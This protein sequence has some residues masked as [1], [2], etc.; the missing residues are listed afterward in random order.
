TGN[1]TLTIASG[2]LLHMASAGSVAPAINFGSAEGMLLENSLLTINGKVSG[3]GGLTKTG[4]G[5]ATL[6]S[7]ASDYTG[8]TTIVAG[9]VTV[10]RDVTAGSP[11]PLGSDSS[12]IVLAA[13]GAFGAN[14]R[15]WVAGQPTITISRN[16]IATGNPSGIPGLGTAIAGP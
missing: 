14:A 6:T 12:A 11:G 15:L 5:G 1:G 3:S 2:A 9:N 10:T 13:G 8:Q 4:L 16:L 7:S